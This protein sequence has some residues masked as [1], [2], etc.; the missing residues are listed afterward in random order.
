VSANSVAGGGWRS[1]GCGEVRAGNAGAEVRLAGWVCR[2][3]DHGGVRFV[4]MRDSTGM[5]QVVFHPERD[6]TFR[7]AAGLHAEYV[8]AVRG[9]VSRRPPNQQNPALATG[10]VEVVADELEVINVARPAPFPVDER[11]AADEALR[12]RYRYIDLRRPSMQRHLRARHQAA[13]AVR[14]YLDAGGFIEIETPALTR[15][16]PEGARDYLVPSRVS[17]GCF[18]ALAQSP[19]LFKQLLVVAGFERYYQ[20]AHCFRDEDMRGDRQPE[21]TQIDIE[22]AFPTE[23][24]VIDLV[25]GT[26]VAVS[27]AVCGKA[28]ATP[29]LRLAWAEAMDR[30]GTDK[31]DLRYGMAIADVTAAAAATSVE[32]FKRAA[33]AGDRVRAIVAPGAASFSR[34]QIDELEAESR[35]RGA[36]GLAWVAFGPEGVRSPLAKHLGPDGASQLAAAAG[37]GQGDLLLVVA[38]PAGLASAVLGHL[39]ARVA[40]RLGLI[41][42]ADLAYAWVTGFPLLERDEATGGWSAMHHPFTAPV[43]EDLD[44][45]ERD[46]GHVRAR[47]YDLVLNGVELGS[48]SIRIHR[49]DVQE[50]VFAALGMDKDEAAARFG[51]LLEAFEYGAPPHGGMAL[52]FDR[53]V[54]MLTGND[55]IREVIA[56]PKTTRAACL[57][58]GAPAVASRQQLAE[59]G[60]AMAAPRAGDGDG[61]ERRDP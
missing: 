9:T 55:T 44:L 6:E 26:M 33:A 46:P 12:L 19:Q 21:F 11:V 15:S 58:T 32:I 25:E 27:R 60:L 10:E 45:L 54:M 30:Y 37:A 1:I 42:A 31:P 57:L 23:D 14:A 18:F 2:T 29:F 49:R 53:I 8:V 13:R 52:G 28:P 20:L 3:R 22:L 38:G 24:Q 4:D 41:P 43:A 47:A 7:Q 39:R 51:F 59:L 17:P 50:R 35:A 48:G 36:R 34:Q 56:F 61:G 16:T 5:I 40:A